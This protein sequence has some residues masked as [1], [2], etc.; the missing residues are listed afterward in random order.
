MVPD[1]PFQLLFETFGR[2][3][4]AHAEA[5]NVRAHRHLAE[6]L[7]VPLV[8]PGGCI[9][10]KAPRAGHGK[11]HLLSRIRHEFEATHECIL[12]RASCGYQI[13][14]GTVMEDVLRH[15]LD[16]T[17]T[18]QR[19]SPMDQLARRLFARALQP[20][21]ESGQVP[22]QDREGALVAL[23]QQP[24][25]TFDFHNPAAVTAQ[26][27][28]ENFEVLAD[29]LSGVLAAECE[30]PFREVN[31]WVGVLYRFAA[32]AAD[33]PKRQRALEQAV[34]SPEMGE[35]AKI[36]R[37]EAL[38]CLMTLTKRVVMIADDLEGFSAEQN[39]ALRLATFVVAIRQ[40]VQRLEFIISLNR[41]VWDGIFVPCLSDGLSDRLSERLIE[42]EPL[43]EAEMVALLESRAPGA[44]A[45]LLARIDRSRAGTH[46]RGLIREAAS[47]WQ[48][49]T[50]GP[51]AHEES[52]PLAAL[53]QATAPAPMPVAPVAPA[54]LSPE[55]LPPAALPIQP[56]APEPSP[57]P[58]Q[59]AEISPTAIDPEPSEAF[60]AEV[61][62]PTPS[63]QD[64]LPPSASPEQP[65]KAELDPADV[66]RVDELLRQ[67]RE[68]F[69]RDRA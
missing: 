52:L 49:S 58:D 64:P 26:W 31:F 69:G 2:L 12:L 19:V 22:S 62:E 37:L 10:L 32:D 46:A 57:T 43:T 27:T 56:P 38:L 61:I 29:R 68:R 20:L 50:A 30:L 25:E 5:V 14:A 39:A 33:Q 51:V 7:E 21:V 23:R 28:R 41:D 47:A 44:G 55:P 48:Q 1:H 11:T 24:L 16:V 35:A 54:P 17:P 9:L 67:F 53:A 34:F 18:A 13:D 4:L 8:K 65:K 3:P 36:A 15:L 66:A 60:A 45:R 6:W 63:A 59:A 40:S 42:L